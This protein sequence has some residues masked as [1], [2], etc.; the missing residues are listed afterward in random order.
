MKN[1]YN[2][3]GSSQYSII[4]GP[5]GPRGI[6]G[7][8]GPQGLPGLQGPT[9]TQGPMGTQGEIGPQGNA[10]PVGLQGETG[11]TGASGPTGET[12]PIGQTGSIGPTGPTGPSALSACSDVQ[13]STLNNQDILRYNFASS[14]WINQEY[15][16]LYTS[17]QIITASTITPDYN[18]IYYSNAGTFNMPASVQGKC[19]KIINIGGTTCTIKFTGRVLWHITNLFNITITTTDASDIEFEGAFGGNNWQLK[20]M[21]GRWTNSLTGKFLTQPTSNLEDLRNVSDTTPSD[22]QLLSYNSG[23][24]QWVPTTSTNNNLLSGLSDVSITTPTHFQRLIYNEVNTRW[25]NQAGT[26]LSFNSGA[27]YATN[28]FL[29]YTNMVN[30]ENIAQILINGS[31]TLTRFLMR[32]SIAPTSGQVTVN[33]RKNT[34]TIFSLTIA[35]VNTSTSSGSLVNFN[36]GE[37]LSLQIIS[38]AST[39]GILYFSFIC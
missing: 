14:K 30:T 37:F 7:P 4:S 8:P 17:T 1:I 35:G 15:F 39:P 5:T 27:N 20:S 18:I 16:G 11:P 26:F 34:L 2:G 33:V 12:G 23:S 13:F 3:G 24:S 29:N 19:I 25:E 36:D 32:T 6:Q 38:N 9:G 28:R 10:G 21:T 31:R 22:G